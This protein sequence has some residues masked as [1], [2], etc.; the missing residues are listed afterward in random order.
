M[1]RYYVGPQITWDDS[2]AWITENNLWTYAW[3]PSEQPDGNRPF[4]YYV[5]DPNA[6]H[7][8]IQV[9]PAEGVS[10]PGGTLKVM[11]TNV[12]LVPFTPHAPELTIENDT[13]PG[14]FRLNGLKPYTYQYIVDNNPVAPDA[15]SPMW[16]DATDIW[17]SSKG[18]ASI[19]ATGDFV[20]IRVKPGTAINASEIQTLAVPKVEFKKIYTF[21]PENDGEV[22][23]EG[24]VSGSAKILVLYEGVFEPG[25][26]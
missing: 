20:H 24:A 3:I 13:M 19:M 25:K 9:A 12:L 22:I 23:F 26:Q 4:N 10:Y 16:D 7:S 18:S 1:L 14:Y 8:Y 5:T 21:T 11:L 15:D 17:V 2:E 6:T